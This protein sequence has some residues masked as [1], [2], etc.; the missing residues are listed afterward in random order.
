MPSLPQRPS[1]KAMPGATQLKAAQFN[2]LNSF[3]DDDDDEDVDIFQTRGGTIHRRPKVS[4]QSS[5]PQAAPSFKARR[6]HAP[7]GK[8]DGLETDFSS[9]LAKAS[10]EDLKIEDEGGGGGGDTVGKYVRARQLLKRAAVSHEKEIS[11]K[12]EGLIE[13]RAAERHMDEMIRLS[14]NTGAPTLK[15]RTTRQMELKLRELTQRRDGAP[16]DKPATDVDNS[17]FRSYVAGEFVSVGENM[18]ALPP[19]L[20][21][22]L[23]MQFGIQRIYMPRNSLTGFEAYH[24][25]AKHL[26]AK[27]FLHVTEI[28]VQHNSKFVHLWDDIGSLASLTRI[29]LAHSAVFE[30]PPSFVWLTQLKYL[31]L[32]HCNFKYLPEK[33]GDLACLEYLNVQRNMLVEL[34]PSFHQLK[35]LKSL[36]ISNNGLAFLAIR[37]PAFGDDPVVVAAW[38]TKV[39]PEDPQ[40]VYYYNRV[41]KESRK[42]MPLCLK[43]RSIKIDSFA[44]LEEGT[45]SYNDRRAQLA[46]QG[47][48][49][50]DANLD[51]KTGSVFY[52]NRVNGATTWEM[53]RNMDTFGICGGLETLKINDN[54]LRDLPNSMSLLTCLRIL[55]VKNNYLR[56]LPEGLGELCSLNSL[57]LSSNELQELPLSMSKLQKMV[58]LVLTANQLTKLDP[59]VG[60]LKSL[61]QLFLGNNRLTALPYKLGYCTELTELQMYN[62]PLE[63]PPYDTV[64]AGS[65]QLL[66][67]LRAKYLQ[68]TQGDTPGVL[69]H[70]FGIRDEKMELLPLFQRRMQQLIHKAK[71]TNE[72]D[73]IQNGLKKIPESVAKLTDL[74]RLNITAQ[75]LEGPECLPTFEQGMTQLHTLWIKRCELSEV[76][77]SIGVLRSLTDV[78]F[79]ENNIQ[80]I[81]FKVFR[82]LKKLETINLCRNQLYNLPE[83]IG[84]IPMLKEL[85]VDMNRIETLPESFTKLKGLTVFSCSMNKLREVPHKLGLLLNLRVLNLEGNQLYRLPEGMGQLHLQELKVSHNRLEIIRSDLLVPNLQT[86]IQILQ[87]SNNNLLQL[88]AIFDGCANLKQLLIDYNPMISPP[89]ELLQEDLETILNYC[90]LRSGRVKE[91]MKMLDNYGFETD[92][93]RF[94]PRARDVIIG[95]SGYLTPI[96]L[97]NVDDQLDGFCNGKFYENAST[98]DEIIDK[99]DAL[100]HQRQYIF[101]NLLFQQLLGVLRDEAIKDEII[102]PRKRFST[103]V[104]PST[105][106]RPWGRN[107]E[108]VFCYA[109]TLEALL[110]DSPPNK[111]VR[112]HRPSIWS[113]T[114]ARL[115]VSVFDYTPEMMKDAISEFV[116]PYGKVAEIEDDVSFDHDEYVHEISGRER[117]KNPCILPALVVTRVIYT[118]SEARRRQEE[119]E[120]LWQCFIDKEADVDGWLLSTIGKKRQNQEVKVRKRA[121]TEGL[122]LIEDEEKECQ[123][124]VLGCK[125]AVELVAARREDFEAGK[126]FFDHRIDSVEDANN[127][128]EAAATALEEAEKA[129][130]EKSIIVAKFH[131]QLNMNRKQ[132][133]VWCERDIKMKYC[134]IAWDELL[135]QYRGESLAEGWRR[136][137]DGIDGAKYDEWANLEEMYISGLAR[138]P[139][140]EQIIGDE[141]EEVDEFDWKGTDKMQNFDSEAYVRYLKEVRPNDLI[142]PWLEPPDES[143]MGEGEEGGEGDVDSDS[144][145]GSEDETEDS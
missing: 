132:L 145:D 16:P 43:L 104:L 71:S 97:K 24:S 89:P 122:R 7:K 93:E 95:S 37:P 63:D 47:V 116:G 32:T 57:R 81:S 1:R 5:P 130:E 69:P 72:L 100:R 92:Q 110:K 134:H 111:Y 128:T 137:W 75:H 59:W 102:F 123:D 44:T 14:T 25:H 45:E 46:S 10:N 20:A 73:L 143:T 77:E 103:N 48:S 124:T 35:N 2:A 86:S 39:D 17:V 119:D 133:M 141:D 38:E 70:K 12:E 41:T 139:I 53:P 121:I 112:R 94:T 6:V 118:G 28:D 27:N 58:E 62:N 65:K 82:H 74:K 90:R 8:R 67:V 126:P 140:K 117:K 11:N 107:G 136:P 115:P 55:E 49:E 9:M 52:N 138:R 50:F 88:P 83:E 98:A 21:N 4:K 87:L 3:H 31:D 19:E 42:A 85:N 84:T 129:L 33:L 40:K 108:M 54:Q 76:D 131:S 96:D 13:A 64:L 144:E 105:L 79:S 22:T 56:K 113:L 127:I 120:N 34:P 99:I 15:N 78:D 36:D 114:K 23:T 30:L 18:T 142:D 29:N 135:T 125:E 101:F 26:S 80:D 60:D 109:V 68:A 51:P 91:V 106:L 61:R 66:Y